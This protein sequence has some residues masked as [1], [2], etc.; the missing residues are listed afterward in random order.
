MYIDTSR[1]IT[2][3]DKVRA[4]THPPAR[5]V[6]RLPLSFVVAGPGLPPPHFAA[7]TCPDAPSDAS[8]YGF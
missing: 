8:N 4:A 7:I 2:L 6:T 1:T 3:T 5:P